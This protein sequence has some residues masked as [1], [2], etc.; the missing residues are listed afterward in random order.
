MTVPF[1]NQYCIVFFQN[2]LNIKIYKT[3]ISPT[4]LYDY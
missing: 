1:Q 4:A 2:I 3:I